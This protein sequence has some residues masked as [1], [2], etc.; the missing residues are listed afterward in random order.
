MDN[1]D[2]APPARR[3]RAVG[4]EERLVDVAA[5]EGP[6]GGSLALDPEA[7]AEAGAG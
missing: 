7:P 6:D 3:H 5:P 4:G 2:R 1:L